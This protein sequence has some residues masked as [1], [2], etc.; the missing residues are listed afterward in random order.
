MAGYD[1]D[2][3]ELIA[4]ALAAMEGAY[5]PYSGFRVG[6]ALEAED[7]RVFAGCNVENS[8]YPVGMCAER[9]ALGHAVESGARRFRRIAVASSGIR[10]AFPCGMCRQALAEFGLHL[11]VIGVTP[12]GERAEWPLGDLLPAAFRLEDADPEVAGRVAAAGDAGGE[13]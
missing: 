2:A 8:S 7:G 6:A 10:P 5:A 4:R 11:L 12:G 1:T 3:E 9:V 13:G